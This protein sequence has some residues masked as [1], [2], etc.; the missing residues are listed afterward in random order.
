MYTSAGKKAGSLV[1]LFCWAHIRR[2]FVR[3]GDANPDQLKYWTHRWLERIRTLYAAHEQLMTAWEQAAAPAPGQAAAAAARLED[4]RAAWDAAIGAI[5]AARKKEMAVPGLQEP[6]KKAL[7]TLDREWGGLIAHRDYPMIGQRRETPGRLRTGPVPALES[8]SRRPARVGAAA[9]ARLMPPS[10]HDSGVT[11]KQRADA[12]CQHACPQDFR[13]LTP[14]QPGPMFR[15]GRRWSPRIPP[16]SNTF[17]GRGLATYYSAN[18]AAT[19]W[20]GE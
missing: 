6:A 10:R 16:S 17:V 13:I 12:A 15:H 19:R 8:Q 4:A 3:A 9:S 20:W 14:Q 5:G 7:A 11:A 2:Y 1:N 18:A